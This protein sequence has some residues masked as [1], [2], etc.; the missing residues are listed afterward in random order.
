MA[1]TIR[2]GDVV[3]FAPACNCPPIWRPLARQL[4]GRTFQVVGTAE[5]LARAALVLQPWP[6]LN[7]FPSYQLAPVDCVGLGG[8]L[9]ERDPAAGEVA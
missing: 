9:I 1:R 6:C 2:L 7:P 8:H 4:E 5:L 3:R